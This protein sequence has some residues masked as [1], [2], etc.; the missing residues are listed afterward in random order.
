MKVALTDRAVA[1][2]VAPA[3]GRL[4]ALDAKMPGL[5]I[6]VAPSGKKTWTVVW[7]RGRQTRRYAFA[8]Y[9]A[10]PLVTA[11]ERARQILADI[12]Q[13]NDPVATRVEQRC[14]P[15]VAALAADYIERY[16]KPRK[17]SWAADRRT[18]DVDVL[19]A[20]GALR[21]NEVQRKHIR[22]V[23]DGI[24]ARGTA[25]RPN[26]T[27]ANRVR[28]LLHS[29]FAFGVRR[30]VLTFNPVDGVE[31]QPERPR[32]KVL[33]ADEVRAIFKA[34]EAERGAM[35]AY[36]RLLFLTG[37]RGGELLRLRWEHVALAPEA[38]LTFPSDITKSK[39][40]HRLPLSGAAVAVMREL[41]E[42]T[43]M[44]AWLFPSTKSAH[45]RR[46]A[47]QDFYKRMRARS[48]VTF[49]GHDARRWCATT[50]AA[51]GIP[52]EVVGRILGHADQSVTARHY[53]KA[54]YASEMRRA[55]EL[56]ARKLDT[57]LTGDVEARV[58]PI[59]SA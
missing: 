53:A 29:V 24:V 17:R 13:G 15:T 54:S 4:E 37:S 34:L 2:L 56:L 42:H 23:L 41:R 28:A 27:H 10:V 40:E 38:W 5:A 22:D 31:R 52:L 16:A 58:V 6:R 30:E 19:P 39:R 49:V 51:A 11:R 36:V 7:H 20:L 48:G 33:T 14:A 44:S 45:G 32:D 12:A 47:N 57:I 9:P 1:K 26:R 18:L 50:M 8:T 46:T 3:G 35:K 55:L 25:A 59:R 43:G 21:A